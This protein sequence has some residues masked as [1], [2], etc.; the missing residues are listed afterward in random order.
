MTS[1]CEHAWVQGGDWGPKH[2][3]PWSSQD[4]YCVLCGL[5]GSEAMFGVGAIVLVEK[6][7]DGR[8]ASWGELSYVFPNS[9]WDMARKIPIYDEG[10]AK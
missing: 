1:E 2:G 8:P 7:G 6:T 3:H 4:R 9:G 5:E 10:G